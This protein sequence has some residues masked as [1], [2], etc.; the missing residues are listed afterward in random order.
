CRS[1]DDLY[2]PCLRKQIRLFV[3]PYPQR[4]RPP[5][6]H[7]LFRRSQS[8]ESSVGLVAQPTSYRGGAEGRVR[9]RSYAMILHGRARFPTRLRDALYEFGY[10]HPSK[11]RSLA[12]RLSLTALSMSRRAALRMTVHLRRLRL[13]KHVPDLAR[14][15]EQFEAR[16]VGLISGVE[17]L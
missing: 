3:S 8:A 17:E 10:V 5:S 7:R 12:V 2:A 4:Q 13:L 9:D 14:R 1:A 6:V 11:S 15:A 16:L